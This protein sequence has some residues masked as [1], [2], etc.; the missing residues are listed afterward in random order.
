MPV[1]ARKER[2]V[3]PA[4]RRGVEWFMAAL[5]NGDEI[6]VVEKHEHQVFA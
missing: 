4:Q 3:T 5:S 1:S 2:R 6:V